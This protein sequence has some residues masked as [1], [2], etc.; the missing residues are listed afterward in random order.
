MER[1]ARVSTTHELL[2][3]TALSTRILRVAVSALF[4]RKIGTFAWA[5]EQLTAGFCL[6]YA[7][8][9]RTED[10]ATYG[11]SILPSF[12]ELFSLAA[13]PGYK[14]GKSEAHIFP[15]L[16]YHKPPMIAPSSA[17]AEAGLRVILLGVFVDSWDGLSA[18]V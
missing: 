7:Q 8:L 1:F 9:L 18:W 15:S 6:H 16:S 5:P 2:T 10:N 14:V 3:E 12:Q 13:P 4:M 17:A 11:V